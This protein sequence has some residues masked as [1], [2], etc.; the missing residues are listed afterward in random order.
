MQRICVGA[1]QRSWL[2][3]KF[4]GWVPDG[5]WNE[6]GANEERGGRVSKIWILAL[7]GS[8]WRNS[9]P[10]KHECSIFGMTSRRS[11][12]DSFTWSAL[13]HSQASWG[14]GQLQALRYTQI[15]A[16]TKGHPNSCW[17]T[18]LSYSW[19]LSHGAH[20]ASPSPLAPPPVTVTCG[21][22]SVPQPN[23]LSCCIFRGGHWKAPIY[24]TKA[25]AIQVH[26]PWGRHPDHQISLC[27]FTPWQYHSS[28]YGSILSQRSWIYNTEEPLQLDTRWAQTTDSDSIDINI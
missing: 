27:F 4:W 21:T 10:R 3:Q 13:L 7:P 26:I 15:C 14:P 5:M 11:S 19:P 9:V 24:G 1:L 12:H 25:S 22:P 17:G 18:A 28:Y 8:T 16:T 20:S 2:T 23:E 6:R